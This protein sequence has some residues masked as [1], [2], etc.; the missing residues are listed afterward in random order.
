[1]KTLLATTPDPGSGTHQAGE[2]LRRDPRDPRRTT[3]DAAESR[4]RA[5]RTSP[6]RRW[7][8]RCSARRPACCATSRISATSRSC[9]RSSRCTASRVVEGDEAGSLV[10]DPS[11][12]ESRR[13]SRRST[14]TPARP[15]SR[16]C[17]AARSCT[18]RSRPSSPTSADA[19]SA[20]GRSTSTWTRCA[21]SAPSWRSSRAASA[22]PRP[23]R[24]ARRE[25]RA[26]RT[27][28]SARPSRCC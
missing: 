9:A 23:Q 12:A 4:S 24:S 14:P 7:W 13:T 28:A 15:A 25:H 22:S 6:P 17:S 19:A 20:T 18:A 3:A 16:S 5:R 11:G 27:R 10:F 8:P 26:A 2:T 21:S 1:M